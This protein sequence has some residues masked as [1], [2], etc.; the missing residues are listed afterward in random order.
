[1]PAWAVRAGAAETLSF[2][3]RVGADAAHPRS[4][5]LVVVDAANGR[6]VQAVK[7]GC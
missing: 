1:V 4:I 7:I 6:Q 3:P 2:T 5:N